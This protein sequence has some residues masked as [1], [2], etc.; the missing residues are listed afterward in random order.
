[1]RFPLAVRLSVA[2]LVLSATT[3]LY[4]AQNPTSHPEKDPPK[5]ASGY[6]SLMCVFGTGNSWKWEWG[7]A[8]DN[9][10]YSM[11][12]EWLTTSITKTTKFKTSH[13]TREI[14][15]ACAQAKEYYKI[16]EDYFAAC[17]R[18]SSVGNPYAIVSDNVQMFPFRC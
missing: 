16:K 1:M 12:G 7:L 18:E 6:T 14:D 9:S 13:G 3:P 2:A 8:A 11:K 4:A 5:L 10:Y 17:A 15:Q